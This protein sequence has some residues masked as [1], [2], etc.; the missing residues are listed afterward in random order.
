MIKEFGKFSTNQILEFIHLA[1]LLQQARSE[2]LIKLRQ[3][4]SKLKESMPDPISWSWAYEIS[5]HE[6]LLK[7][8]H[9]CGESQ[10]IIDFSKAADPQQAVI[11]AIKSDSPL[12]ADSNTPVQSILALTE[13][14]ACSFECMIIYGKYIHEIFSDVK[15]NIDGSTEWL[16]KAIRIDPNIVTSATF[17]DRLCRAILLEDKDFLNELQKALKGKTGSQAKYLNDFRFLMQLLSESDTPDLTDS[18]IN[19]LV[20]ELGIYSNTSSAQHNISELIRKHKK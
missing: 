2:Y 8:V 7:V 3:N 20:L 4:P 5:I 9:L 13:A 19:A 1:P 15:A 11:D 14:L 10:A 17:Q 12:Y 16:F 18:K 6:H